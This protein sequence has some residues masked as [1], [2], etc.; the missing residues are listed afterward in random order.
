M[1]LSLKYNFILAMQFS[2][3]PNYHSS[4]YSISSR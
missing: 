2:S 1:K 4:E 3:V